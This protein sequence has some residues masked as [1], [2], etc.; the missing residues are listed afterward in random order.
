MSTNNIYFCG[1]IRKKTR[2]DS[3]P[4]IAHFV[5]GKFKVCDLVFDMTWDEVGVGGL[6]CAKYSSSQR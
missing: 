3:S 1:E 6:P 5:S 2:L 4:D